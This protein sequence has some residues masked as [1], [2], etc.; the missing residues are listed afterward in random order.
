MGTT[1]LSDQTKRQMEI[2]RIKQEADE[3]FR[4]VRS[5]F[6]PQ[7][8]EVYRKGDNVLITAHGFYFPS[9]EAEIKTIHFPLMNKLI[10]AIR[11]FPGSK[12]EVSGHTDA[13]GSAEKNLLISKDRAKNVA[14]FLI[15]VGH[16]KRTDITVNGYG[17]TRPIARNYT[18]QGRAQNRRIELLII[19]E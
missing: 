10:N 5:L 13:T 18:E 11:K 3:R 1:L 14:D 16:V 19:N 4:H 2:D 17:E 7:E 12:I 9:G 6:T 15:N 8:A